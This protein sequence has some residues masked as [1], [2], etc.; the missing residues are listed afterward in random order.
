MIKDTITFRPRYDEVDQMGYM[1]HAHYVTYC[2][3]AR[4][5][6]MRKYGICDCF[7]E[8]QNVM[9]PVVEMNVRYK[10]PAHYDEIIYIETFIYK[11]PLVRFFFNFIFKNSKNEVI[12]TADST[13]VFVNKD[14]R[15]PIKTPQL[16]LDMLKPYL[17]VEKNKS[18]EGNS[19]SEIM[20][21]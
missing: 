12:C 2:H 13:I 19:L 3:I 5:E 9:M 20:I 11:E 17:S 7:I 8:E 4:T 10:H 21:G 14:D 1:Y 6:L 18:L 16:V 15:K